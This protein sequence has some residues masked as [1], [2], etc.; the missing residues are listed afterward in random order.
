[1]SELFTEEL[2]D[3]LKL[4]K[5]GYTEAELRETG[6]LKLVQELLAERR[7]L[8]HWIPFA[9]KRVMVLGAGYGSLTDELLSQGAQVDALEQNEECADVLRFRF[10]GHQGL[11]VYERGLE[12]LSRRGADY[13]YILLDGGLANETIRDMAYAYFYE[14]RVEGSDDATNVLRHF[15]QCLAGFLQP[16]GRIILVTDNRMGMKYLSSTNQEEIPFGQFCGIYEET[17][18]TRF[19]YGE[20]RQLF[21]D[22]SLHA[23]FYFPTPDAIFPEYI[24]SEQH[25]PEGDAYFNDGLA[26]NDGVRLFHEEGAF[27]TVLKEGLFPQFASSFLC[28]LER[29]DSKCLDLAAYVKYSTRRKSEYAISTELYEPQEEPYHVVKRAFDA[30]SVNHVQNILTL[31]KD[32]A[33]AL[34]NTK[35]QPCMSHG[36]EREDCVSFDYAPGVSFE[37]KLDELVFSGNTQQAY[38][39]MS[40]FFEEL[41]RAATKEFYLM[42]E[43][44]EIFLGQMKWRQ[45]PDVTMSVTDVD[46]IFS[47]VICDKT[48]WWIIDYEWSFRFPIPFRF[49]M[50]R[51]L[52]YYLHAKPRRMQVLTEDLYTRFGFDQEEI[53]YYEEMEENFQLYIYHGRRPIYEEDGCKSEIGNAKVTE[54]GH[55]AASTEE[56]HVVAVPMTEHTLDVRV[57]GFKNLAE[58][59]IIMGYAIAKD[60]VHIEL[61]DGAGQEIP[62]GIRRVGRPDANEKYTNVS[63][64]YRA[65]FILRM[66]KDNGERKYPLTL[67]F[68]CGEER[69]RVKVSRR[70]METENAPTLIRRIAHVAKHGT[71]TLLKEGPAGL[72]RKAQNKKA[73]DTVDKSKRLP[74]NEVEAYRNWIAGNEPDEAALQKQ[75]EAASYLMQAPKFSIVTSVGNISNEEFQRFFESVLAQTYTNWE[76]YILD[77]RVD[78]AREALVGGALKDGRITYEIHEEDSSEQKDLNLFAK[79][80]TGD[81]VW[82]VDPRD[83]IAPFAL[84]ECARAYL[85][86]P[87]VDALYWDHDT[88]TDNQLRRSPWFKPD[89][90][91]D[92]LRSNN[93]ILQIPM[94]RREVMERVGGMDEHF[95]LGWSYDYILRIMEQSARVVHIPKVLY[96]RGSRPLGNV[97]DGYAAEAMEILDA[98]Y[99]RMG[100]PA[101]VVQT[102]HMGIFETIYDWKEQPLISIII[103]NKDHTDDLDRCI[104]S[105][106]EKSQ[107]RNFEIIV[108]ENNSEDS[109]TFEYYEQLTATWDCVRVVAYAGSFN[110]SK[111]N[112]FGVSFARGEYVLLLNNDT[113]CIDAHLLD[114]MLGYAMRED[115]GI[116]GARLFYEDGSIQHAGVVVGYGGV[117]AHAFTGFSKEQLG[118]MNRI[119]T[120]LNYSAVTAACLMTKK[121]LFEEVGGLT[122]ALAVAF[123]DVDFCLKVRSLGKLVVYNPWAMAN[124]YESK[125]RGYDEEPE[126]KARFQREMDFFRKHWKRILREGDPYYNPNL[127]LEREDFSIRA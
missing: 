35:F 8:I 99:Q 83:S 15:L 97:Q 38:Q 98:H 92:F 3:F 54:S 60:I 74:M 121:A 66:E 84:Y 80:S 27:M 113:E 50:F 37:S 62:I 20:L 53:M 112:N 108:V 70:Q 69:R 87:M 28:I 41:R 101:H 42:P 91:M 76:L 49:V 40:G 59:S 88:V 57:D 17:G 79:R 115:V 125:S 81:F 95:A 31:Q 58:A 11:S 120:T 109:Q 94:M 1:M 9:D 26:W 29:K 22:A 102:E 52:Y 105:L 123:N 65:G 89:L 77:H 39:L 117:A 106:M 118:A 18:Q 72:Y 56:R 86:N 68:S 75:K 127:T 13:D 10:R 21:R 2:M 90:S 33:G 4:H 48:K 7:N 12:F 32:L 64:D 46:L 16:S 126:K 36:S 71:L 25:L 61:T 96:H 85:E 51:C 5:D 82:F 100:L 110:Y 45:T 114:R 67:T 78:R 24:Y 19:T 93:Y 107:Y 23:H 6:N 104:V 30:Q 103:P 124:H 122:E 47:N 43:F 34:A 119:V 111:I 55:V 116:V 73:E 63:G 44:N 14:S